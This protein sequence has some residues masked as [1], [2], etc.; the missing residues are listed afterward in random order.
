MIERARYARV[1]GIPRAQIAL[2]GWVPL[3]DR[4]LLDFF[5]AIQEAL[6]DVELIHYNIATSGRFLSGADY[7]AILKVAP[8]LRGSKHTDGN[9]SSLIEITQA[10]PTLAHFVVDHQIMHGALF[11]AKGFYSFVANLNPAVTAELWQACGAGDWERAAAIKI[12]LER[13]FD[14]WRPLWGDITV[15][16]ALAKI[17]AAAGIFPD[18]PLAVR[19]P[20][21]AGTGRQVDELRRPIETDFPDLLTSA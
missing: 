17:A 14:A 11:G 1:Q 16:P 6:P 9:V 20:Y 3:G 10:T 15:S 18:M 19:A 21:G 8:N 12:L 13:F 7:K 2:P 4:E 5:A